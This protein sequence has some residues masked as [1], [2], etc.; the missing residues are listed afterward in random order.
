[1][2]TTILKYIHKYLFILQLPFGIKFKSI[3]P[4]LA[5]IFLIG[6]SFILKTELIYNEIFNHFRQIIIILAI[7]YSC[8]LLI[9]LIVR[10]Y[11]FFL[12]TSLFFIRKYSSQKQLAFGFYTLGSFYIIFNIM[13]LISIYRDLLKYDASLVH[14]LSVFVFY[15]LIIAI[16]YIDYIS[17]E[18]IKI[19]RNTS[20]IKK[21][22]LSY[23][24]VILNILL[25]I[26]NFIFLMNISYISLVS[27]LSLDIKFYFLNPEDINSGNQD[28]NTSS[29]YFIHNGRDKSFKLNFDLNKL[30]KEKGLPYFTDRFHPSNEENREKFIDILRKHYFDR[31]ISV[32]RWGYIYDHQFLI[33]ERYYTTFDL[34]TRLTLMD[35]F[36]RDLLWNN[37]LSQNKIRL[38]QIAEFER[39]TNLEAAY[40][41][42][43]DNI[44]EPPAFKYLNYKGGF[45]TKACATITFR[46]I[47]DTIAVDNFLEEY[48]SKLILAKYGLKR[49]GKIREG[50]HLKY[51]AISEEF[52]DN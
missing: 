12:R 23:F 18:D 40:Q 42:P 25:L 6:A 49:P 5:L 10:M 3:K 7:F 48:E 46:N 37:Y 41:R 45:P 4:L 30:Y 19:N 15:S 35:I 44:Y 16:V 9:N 2:K 11:N 50:D 43:I 52:K 24:L 51:I 34:N 20:I 14:S 38:R 47:K 27:K 36:T 21:Y 13:L 17:D 29:K 39:I 32:R 8:F 26:F 33:F 28:N 31:T 1:M 22:S